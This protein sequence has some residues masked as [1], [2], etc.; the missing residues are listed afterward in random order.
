MIAIF[1]DTSFLDVVRAGRSDFCRRQQLPTAETRLRRHLS[2]STGFH[3][4]VLEL[5][6][7]SDRIQRRIR[8]HIGGGLVI[9]ERNGDRVLR[10]A[11]VGTRD[12]VFRGALLLFIGW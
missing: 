12:S 10:G 3:C 7:L 5:R 4:A 1:I 9:A 8:Q 11:F 2:A 6:D